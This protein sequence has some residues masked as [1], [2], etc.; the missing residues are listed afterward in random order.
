MKTILRINGTNNALFQMLDNDSP[1]EIIKRADMSKYSDEHKR[2]MFDL[3]NS[4]DLTR[5]VWTSEV[6]DLLLNVEFSSLE[7]STNSL[8]CISSRHFKAYKKA[9]SI[10][11]RVESK[12]SGCLSMD[13]ESNLMQLIKV[14]QVQAVYIEID[15]QRKVF[16]KTITLANLSTILEA[17]NQH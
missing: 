13:L 1:F 10:V 14:M 8:G 12:Y 6:Q 15:G 17:I 3:A 11:D 4:G 16:T 5:L 7:V 9:F 2:Y